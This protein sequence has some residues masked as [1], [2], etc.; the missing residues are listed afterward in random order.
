MPGIGFS[1]DK[2]LQA[3]LFSYGD[4]QRY[5]LG[6]NSHQ[7]PVNAPRCPFHSYH[8]DGAMRVDGNQ[9]ARRLL[10][11][12]SRN[13]PRSP[14]EPT[15]LPLEGAAA[16]WDHRVDD[17]Y[18]AA[19]R[20]V[21]PD[22]RQPAAG[23]VRQHRA[24]HRRGD[25]H[26]QQRH[27]ANCTAS[28][29]PMAQASRRHSG[30][31]LPQQRNEENDMTKGTALITGASSGIGAVY[32]DRLARRGYDLL[33]VARDA[34]PLS[35]LAARIG[36]DQGVQVETQPADLGNAE[37][38][39]KVAQRLMN[40]GG[41]TM[42]VNSA[43]VGPRG[44]FLGSEPIDLSDMVDLNVSALHDLT[45][46]AA[47]TFAIRRSGAI[48]NIASVVALMPEHFNASYVASKAFVLGLTQALAADLA[49][50]GVRIQAVLPGFTRTEIFDRAGVG[51]HVINPEMLM[52]AGDMVDAALAGFD[53]SETVTIPS[54]SDAG[55]WAAMESARWA[56]APHLSLKHP[57]ARF[58]VRSG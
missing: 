32:A 39:A 7:I 6:V 52:E 15:T 34:R 16:H 50:C 44:S 54:L 3:R 1:P 14:A 11:N 43:G 56:L 20:P 19:R 12:P 21:P 36:R 22:D 26:V 18:F 31:I 4:A 17:D 37:D 30:T 41:V 49:V 47:Q 33:L 42:L 29:P 24:L 55:L 5:R 45:I 23:A 51:I 27:I 35:D 40:G 46:A 2:M 9:G 8:R 25:R 48:I 57:A 28:T 53:L 58:G 10:P 38:V 13:G